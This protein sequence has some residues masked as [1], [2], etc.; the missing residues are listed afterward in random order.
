MSLLKEAM[1]DFTLIDKTSVPDG[2]GGKT[3]VWKDGATIKA[4]L[5][6][7]NSIEAQIAMKQ[8]VT[9]VYTLITKRDVVLAYH[10]VLRRESD[11]K[12]LRVTQDGDDVKTPP[13]SSLDMRTVT[14]EEWRLDG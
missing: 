10:D 9:S 1:E 3:N 4:A 2:Y 13:S 12:I 14:C 7:N 8:G 6:F 11:K 5:V